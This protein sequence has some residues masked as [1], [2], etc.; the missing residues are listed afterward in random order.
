MCCLAC[1]ACVFLLFVPGHLA[2]RERK[3]YRA[4]AF[5]KFYA[6]CGEV[7]RADPKVFTL[8]GEALT[9]LRRLGLG[10]AQILELEE[11]KPV[12]F[13]L[14]GAADG[15]VGVAQFTRPARLRVG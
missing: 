14:A 11:G 1:V 13:N 5:Q 6:F 8:T 10:D 3:R 2:N 9:T 4:T 7:Q 15:T 12:A